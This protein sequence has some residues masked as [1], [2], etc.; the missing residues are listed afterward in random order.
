MAIIK[1]KMCGG[2]LNITE[3]LSVAECEYC[4]SKQT[5]PSVDNEKKLTL[6]NRAGRLLRGCEFDKAAGLF[7]SIVAEFPEEAEAYWCLVLCKYGIEYVDDP[8]TGKKVPTCH[9]SSFESVMDDP[10]F[11]QACEYNDAIARRV[12]RDEARQIEELRKR[13]IE[14]SGREVPYD[15]FISYKETDENGNRT[16]DSVIA[17][18]I[19]D[20][21]CGK[22]YRVFFSRISLEDKLGT[23]YEPYI[24]AALNSAKVMLVVGTDYENFDSVWVKNEWSRFLKLMTQ[25]NSKHLVPVYRNMDA[26]DL[27]KEFAKL[28]AQDMG[29]L[30]AMQDLLHGIEKII[31]LKGEVNR[32]TEI[33][34]N[35][36]TAPLEKRIYSLLAAGEWNKVDICCE[37]LLNLDTENPHAYIGKLMAKLRVK[38]IEDLQNCAQPFE[39]NENYKKAVEYADTNISTQLQDYV[40]HIKTRNERE[41]KRKEA[42]A[43]KTARKVKKICAI[44]IPA[45][46]ACIALAIFS[47]KVLIPNAN[48]NKAE[49]LHAAGDYEAS[50]EIYMTL[51]DY[52]DSYGRYIASK[53]AL[54][55]SLMASREYESAMKIYLQI[56]DSALY[57]QANY[58]LGEALLGEDNYE[59]AIAAFSNNGNYSDA[60]EK[61]KEAKYRWAE[62]LYAEGDYYAAEEKFAELGEYK[63]SESYI[64]KINRQLLQ[65]AEVG[66]IVK[67]GKAGIVSQTDVT[68]CVLDKVDNKMLVISEMILYTDEYDGNSLY[69]NDWS[70]TGGTSEWASS[71]LCKALQKHTGDLTSRNNYFNS[72]ETKMILDTY[73][74]TPDNPKYGTS[75]GP[76]TV[77]KLFL[78][79]IDEAEKYF[80]SDEDRIA[81]ILG[82]TT[83]GSWWLRSPGATSYSV[84]YVSKDGSIPYQGIR[85]MK[86]GIGVRPAMWIDLS[87]L[88]Q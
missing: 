65:T 74:H 33:Y 26:Y 54:A 86:N 69:A 75:A 81:M 27:P 12:Y 2:D 46:V 29:K 57:Q 77:N 76:D 1:C 10:N 15:I 59:A 25:D 11:E 52:K 34:S 35:L 73:I 63:D 22:G 14:V 55:E 61:I 45:V 9:R 36:S 60:A 38:A 30:G 13:I 66:D 79:S 40:E 56:E 48:Y 49:K 68:W 7:E 32:V 16:L 84:A 47:T 39:Q 4:G 50:S 88:S 70:Y 20:A 53:Y 28:V 18:D 43:R 24:F 3:G 67:I 58:A 44:V 62:E 72:E 37:Q 19:Y 80:S 6:F 41:R 64:E 31:P 78:L 87:L 85:P 51:G 71:D 5:I 21:L 82:S 23:E 42:A 8:A 17:Q 83:N